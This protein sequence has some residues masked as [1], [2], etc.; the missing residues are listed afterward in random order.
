MREAALEGCL[1]P[2]QDRLPESDL[3]RRCGVGGKPCE[4]ERCAV[5]SQMPSGASVLREYPADYTASSRA[6]LLPKR[7]AST[8][9]WC[10]MRTKRFDRGLLSLRSKAT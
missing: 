8:S 4:T 7:S 9:I 6:R 5:G 3:A 1:F 10:S 2:L